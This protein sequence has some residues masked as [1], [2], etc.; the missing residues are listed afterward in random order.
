MLDLVVVTSSPRLD[1]P[2]AV[3]EKELALLRNVEWTQE[4]G[5]NRACALPRELVCNLARKEEMA[6]D[7]LVLR[8]SSLIRSCGFRSLQQVV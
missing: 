3:R 2:A 6:V 7:K 4:S 1:L 5:G 8:L